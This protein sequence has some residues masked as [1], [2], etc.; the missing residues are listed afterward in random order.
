MTTSVLPDVFVEFSLE[1]LSTS[2][3]RNVRVTTL[4][5]AQFPDGTCAPTG[6]GM[7]AASIAV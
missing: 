6:P 2:C 1:D 5:R 3:S 4:V 7:V